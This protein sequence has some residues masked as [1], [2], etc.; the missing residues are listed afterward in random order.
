MTDDQR[1]ISHCGFASRVI[2]ISGLFVFQ[3]V[4]VSI[5]EEIYDRIVNPELDKDHYQGHDKLNRTKNAI[6][7]ANIVCAEECSYE[8]RVQDQQSNQN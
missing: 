8:Q 2:T 3:V 4:Q 1:P 5:A 7:H 6:V